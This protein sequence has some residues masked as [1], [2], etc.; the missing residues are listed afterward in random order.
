M[1]SFSLMFSSL[2]IGVFASVVFSI[3]QKCCFKEQ[4]EPNSIRKGRELT[5]MIIKNTARIVAQICKEIRFQKNC[6]I[7]MEM[8]LIS[9]EKSV[10]PASRQTGSFDGNVLIVRENGN[11]SSRERET[12]IGLN[13]HAVHRNNPKY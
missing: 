12:R 10:Y 6:S 3:G 5:W 9:P 4:T 8:P 11:G 13:G 1:F 7:I 2:V